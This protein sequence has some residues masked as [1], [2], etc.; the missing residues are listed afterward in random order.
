LRF[1]SPHDSIDEDEL[2]EDNY[3]RRTYYGLVPIDGFTYSR[4]LNPAS[5]RF[6]VKLLNDRR[7]NKRLMGQ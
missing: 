7:Y 4:K 2:E 3:Q 6:L 5:K 1:A